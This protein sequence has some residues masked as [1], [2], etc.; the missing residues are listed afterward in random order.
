MRAPSLP[1]Y[2]EL[3]AQ[4]LAG[5]PAPICPVFAHCH[6]PA[7]DQDAASLA[8]AT[9]AWQSRFDMD[10]VKLTPASTWQLRDYGVTDAL[11]PADAL[12]RRRITRT[13]IGQAMDWQHLPLLD[14]GRG[15]AARIVRATALVRRRLPAGVPLLATLYSP[16]SLA[17]KL[18]V[19]GLASRH[20]V[21][22]PAALAAG[23]SILTENCRRLVVALGGAGAD[24][25]FLA[26]QAARA[27]LFTAVDYTRLCLAGDLACLDAATGLPFNILHLHGDSIHHDLFSPARPAL[28]HYDMSP[29]NPTPESLHRPGGVGLSTGPRPDGVITHGNPAQCAAELSA[30]LDRLRGPGFVLAPG[31]TLPLGAPSAN[32]DMLIR[33]ARTP[34]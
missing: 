34:R 6:H 7:A 26:V 3:L 10:L 29:G 11:D 16:A 28:L 13:I 24:G 23:L 32:L 5:Q 18:A 4:T 21:E 30:L 12:G 19:P 20:A 31:C 17:V 14:P 2:G 15:F 22:A 1:R 33:L 9:L 25:I 8:D 27:P